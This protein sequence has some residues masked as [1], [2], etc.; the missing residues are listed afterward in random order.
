MKADLQ[1]SPETYY[2]S[3]SELCRTT[4]VLRDEHLIHFITQFSTFFCQ[5]DYAFTC[6]CLF[7]SRTQ[8]VPNQFLP[9]NSGADCDQLLWIWILFSEVWWMVFYNGLGEGLSSLNALLVYSLSYF[10]LGCLVKH[11][12]SLNA[13]LPWQMPT[14]SFL[15]WPHTYAT[16]VHNTQTWN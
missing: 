3:I 2:L 10:L 16:S 12:Q 7:V 6:V 1:Q 9:I 15:G 8:T 13:F 4:L 14:V 11:K 5:E